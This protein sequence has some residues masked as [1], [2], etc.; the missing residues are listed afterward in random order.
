MF[1]YSLVASPM[2][3]YSI[4]FHDEIEDNY[5]FSTLFVLSCIYI[6]LYMVD[7]EHLTQLWRKCSMLLLL[8]F[9]SYIFMILLFLRVILFLEMNAHADI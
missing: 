1:Q 3:T 5:Q 7:S 6:P 4:C 9:F 2:S 8:F